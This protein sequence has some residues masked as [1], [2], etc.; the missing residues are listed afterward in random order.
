M[1]RLYDQ[2]TQTDFYRQREE[3]ILQRLLK[4]P[5]FGQPLV[6]KAEPP[7]HDPS[8]VI[9]YT[10]CV[11]GSLGLPLDGD[12]VTAYLILLKNHALDGEWPEI[13]RLLSELYSHANEEA[14]A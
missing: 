5:M 2:F 12:N 13:A 14:I 1:K 7:V 10:G 4:T 6:G 8:D 11:A 9:Y 3:A